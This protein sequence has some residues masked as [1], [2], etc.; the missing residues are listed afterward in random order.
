MAMSEIVLQI[1][2]DINLEGVVSLLAPYIKNAEIKQ[3]TGK[4]KGKIW[5]G[6]MACL[7]NP[8][9]ADFFTP[10]KR[11]DLYDR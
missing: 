2:D 3:K 10:L 5:D 7:Q 8:W 11:N 6:D 1:N 4:P 9:K